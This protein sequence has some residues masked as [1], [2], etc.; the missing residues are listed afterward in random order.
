[1]TRTKRRLLC[2][3]S[4][5]AA[6][7]A[8]WWHIEGVEMKGDY[9]EVATSPRNTLLVAVVCNHLHAVDD[10]WFGFPSCC[11]TS[12]CVL[13]TA[14]T[15]LFKVTIP[16]I[17]QPPSLLEPRA[18]TDSALAFGTLVIMSSKKP[19]RD[20]FQS[21]ETADPTDLTF[22]CREENFKVHKSVVCA[23]SPM[24]RAAVNGNFKVQPLCVLRKSEDC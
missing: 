22:S 2:S 9:D 7:Q 13:Q 4:Q 18:I 14:S 12:F 20:P 19:N 6:P 3:F 5:P 16:R 8:F 11:M 1:M 24:L 15:L 23:Q 21:L 17:F 10:Y